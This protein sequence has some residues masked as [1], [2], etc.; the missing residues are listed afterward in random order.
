VRAFP[1]QH[2]ADFDNEPPLIGSRGG[3]PPATEHASGTLGPGDRLFLMTD[4]L[5]Q[6]FLS[7][8]EQGRRP[9]EAVAA[10]LDAGRPEDAFATWVERL[11]AG[12]GLRDDDVTLVAIEPGPVPEE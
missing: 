12:D 2:A 3:V 10:L 4:A 11:R 6:W 1:V 9:W 5:A 7:A 8:H